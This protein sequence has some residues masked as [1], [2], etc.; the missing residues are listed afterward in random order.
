MSSTIVAIIGAVLAS[1]ALFGF[2][3]F[4]ITRKDN[5]FKKAMS[6]LER[7]VLRTQL[8]V[9][10]VLN[11]VNNA[12]I[13]DSYF[14]RAIIDWVCVLSRFSNFSYG[15]FDFSAL[16]YY[17]SITSVFLFLTVRVYEK[18]RWG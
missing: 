11:F 8:L 18:R 13:I 6:R 2:I 16:L 14:L 15:I 1:N 17:L 12:E 4:I 10:V 3:Q 5:S 7:D 9:M